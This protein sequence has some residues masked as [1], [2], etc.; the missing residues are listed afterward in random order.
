MS[1]EQ[2]ERDE[3]NSSI[4]IEQIRLDSISDDN[5]RELVVNLVEST[6]TVEDVPNVKA[7]MAV[8]DRMIEIQE[9]IRNLYPDFFDEQASREQRDAAYPAHTL[10]EHVRGNT[11]S[12]KAIIEKGH[13]FG[14]KADDKYVAMAG[15]RGK[16]TMSIGRPVFELTKASVLPEHR[17]RGFGGALKRKRVQE[18]R[19]NHPT[20]VIVGVTKNPMLKAKYQASEDWREEPISSQSEISRIVNGGIDQGELSRMEEAGYKTYINEPK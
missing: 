19:D 13:M 14:I 6:L 16:G 11:G 18:V 9:E 15:F 8:R 5:L 7:S 2:K 1:A 20:A 12:I 3:S 10:N 4:P 17:G